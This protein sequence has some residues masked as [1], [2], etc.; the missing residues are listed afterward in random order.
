MRIEYDNKFVNPLFSRTEV[1]F[2]I[3]HDGVTPSRKDVIKK[4]AEEFKSSEDLIILDYIR[5]PY[6]TKRCF[7]RAKVY[8]DVESM[9]IEPKHLVIR[10]D[11]ALG[12]EVP[13]KEK[14][15]KK[16]KKKK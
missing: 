10:K 16:S 7:G 14:K 2:V 1:N 5:Q 11:K 12:K 3:A 4:I 15:K 13:K 8:N 6:G 9:K